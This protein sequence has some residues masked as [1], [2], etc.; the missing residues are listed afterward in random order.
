MKNDWGNRELGAGNRGAFTLIELL[1]VVAVIAILASLL[2]PALAATKSK[3]HAISC[4]NN[5]RQLALATL[6]YA[7]DSADA[8]PYNTGADEIKQWVGSK[9][10]WNW[11][12]PVM[13]WEASNSDNT[14]SALVT[15]GGIGPYTS[16]TP[17]IYRCPSD[18]VVS[19]KQAA[20]GWTG[21]VR[22]ISMNAMV[23]DAGE[24][25]VAGQNV[26]NRDYVQFLKQSQ[27]LQPSQIF[28]FIEEH[29]DS[30]NDGYFLNHVDSQRWFDLPASYH[31][32]AAN[33]TFVDGHLERH[34]W[35]SS[36][37]KPPSQAEAAALP[38]PSAPNV[39]GSD[40]LIDFNWL[41]DRTTVDQ[42]PDPDE[43]SYP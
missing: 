33:L 39:L 7:D 12:S 21:R 25:I 30:I 36:S 41:M 5:E 42:N 19:D 9:W 1:V 23:G 14:N 32:G 43:Y 22:S 16:R 24:Y 27:V 34:K 31:N 17:A 11:T 3:G 10:Y 18:H 29:P 40:A 37:T 15:L 8:L 6:L 4:L 26:N 28:V 13:D 2:L 20:V 35:R 38:F